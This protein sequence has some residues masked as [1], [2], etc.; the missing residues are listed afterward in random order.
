[1]TVVDPDNLPVPHTQVSVAA[2]SLRHAL[3]AAL[4]L[5]VIEDTLTEFHAVKGRR[6]DGATVV[7]TYPEVG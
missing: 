4:E 5:G 6:A 7:I 1:V 3:T 2:K